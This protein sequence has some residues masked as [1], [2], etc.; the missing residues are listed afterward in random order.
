[1][2]NR[3]S[4]EREETTLI[5]EGKPIGASQEK[6]LV[7]T[8]FMDFVGYSRLSLDSQVKVQQVLQEMVMRTVPYRTAKANHGLLLR[9][10]GDGMALIFF[11]DPEIHED[12]AYPL[13]CAIE[14]DYVLKHQ[15]RQLR[16]KV[17]AN[18]R[19]RMG[20]HTGPVVLFSGA[21]NEIEVAGEGI[22]VAARVMD[23]G[24]EGHIL[25]SSTVAQQIVDRP[26][27]KDCLWD[28]GACRVKHDHLVYLYN[29]TG[30]HQ[31]G[32]LLGNETIPHLV[33]Q[34]RER[35]QEQSVRAQER[36][37]EETQ[38]AKRSI[39]LRVGAGVL[40]LGII[41]GV[42]ASW[43]A[44]ARSMDYTQ[45]NKK[46]AQAVRERLAEKEKRDLEA[47]KH[48]PKAVLP[49]TPAP[50]QMLAPHQANTPSGASV[51]VPSVVGLTQDEARQ[52]AAQSA[53]TLQESLK[54]PAQYHP[55]IPLGSIISQFPEPASAV[56]GD[57]Q[58]FVVL[59]LGPQ[60]PVAAIPP[61]QENAA[62]YT[63]IVIDA[64]Q[65][66]RGN[67]P[68][69]LYSEQSPNFLQNVATTTDVNSAMRLV[70]SKPLQIYALGA[71]SQ[72]VK[73]PDDATKLWQTL[74]ASTRARVIVLTGE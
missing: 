40:A 64:R 25:V 20:V 63:G 54:S 73:I 48:R 2:E 11:D 38:E 70:G 14:I 17:G 5:L 33:H 58:L 67:S 49:A 51:S 35:A 72:G 42:V 3:E 68:A 61:P 19:L 23:A 13:Q 59:S 12:V 47:A 26:E 36:L 15:L 43:R 69:S 52:R 56:P 30:K 18:F 65:V 53:L 66:L 44:I 27:W 57:K 41:A 24:D 50:I 4:V 74:P 34:N 46:T 31:D 8:L 45:F 10:T 62:L 60:P 21:D 6:R 9:K 39:Y 32:T 1:M 55:T 29:L 16:D 7:H 22:N 71:G 28:L 37:I